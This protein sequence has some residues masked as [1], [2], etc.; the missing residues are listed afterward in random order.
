MGKTKA[1]TFRSG[2]WGSCS[3]MARVSSRLVQGVGE[4]AFDR[5]GGFGRHFLSVLGEVLGLRDERIKLLAQKGAVE[6]DDFRIRLGVHHVAHRSKA[7]SLL[8]RVVSIS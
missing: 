4:V 1:R 2:P 8:A 6:L 5:L 3:G 7:A